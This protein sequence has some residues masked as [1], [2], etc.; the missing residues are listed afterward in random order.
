M[1]SNTVAGHIGREFVAEAL[2]QKWTFSRWTYGVWV[3]FAKWAKTQLPDP[4]VVA[5]DGIEQAAVKDAEIL[6]RLSQQDANEI[7]LAAKEGRVPV[8][9]LDKW[10]PLSDTLT[11]KAQELASCYLDFSS[12][13][14][15]SLL[16]SPVGAAYV[17]Y[18]LLKGKHPDATPDLAY[19][20][21]TVLGA[22]T[23]REIF[24]QVQ[25]KAPQPAG[26]PKNGDSP[27]A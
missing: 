22:D 5:L 9:V 10:T 3:E 15:R 4:I 26:D 11:N 17:M 7:T 21:F 25:G 1:S 24:D 2:G 20:L 16:T 6:R 12:K 23:V 13:Q 18:L 19:D 27:A 8:L 14:F